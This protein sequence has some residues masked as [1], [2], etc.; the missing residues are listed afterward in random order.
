MKAMVKEKEVSF[1][2]LQEAKEPYFLKKCALVEF[3]RKSGKVVATLEAFGFAM[4]H[5]W[6]ITHIT[7]TRDIAIWCKETKEVLFYMEGNET[8]FKDYGFIP[9]MMIGDLCQALVS[10]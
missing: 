7:K 6:A 1:K 4:L 5:A 8:G 9:D 3:G 10:V 2:E